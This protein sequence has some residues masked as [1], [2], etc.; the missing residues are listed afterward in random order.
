M[1]FL[2]EDVLLHT[3]TFSDSQTLCA[4]ISTCRTF[5]QH[6]AKYLIEDEVTLSKNRNVKS[7]FLFMTCDNLHRI[8]YLRRLT[9]IINR[10]T[11]DSR[12]IADSMETAEVVKELL[13]LLA[14]G[15]KLVQLA[16]IRAE[17]ILLGCRELSVA[18]C[19]L[20]TLRSLILTQVGPLTSDM[21]Q[22]LTIPLVSIAVEE[23]SAFATPIP[24]IRNPTQFLCGTQET[25]RELS[26][27]YFEVAGPN[28]SCY[29]NVHSLSLRYTD[30]LDTQHYVHAFPN[31]KNL[32][33]VYG[34]PSEIEEDEGLAALR[35]KNRHAQQLFG[36]WPSLRRYRGSLQDLYVLGISC[37]VSSIS[38]VDDEHH[39]LLPS[40]LHAVCDDA[41]PEHLDLRL[42]M[43]PTWLFHP[44]FYATFS[45]PSAQTLLHLEL[46]FY[47]HEEN[48]SEFDDL[49]QGLD[50]V[51]LRIVA[52]LRSLSRFKLTIS[53]R[54]VGL[55]S[56]EDT[57][58]LH[59]EHTPYAVEEHLVKWDLGAY[60]RRCRDANEAKTLKSVTITLFTRHAWEGV[61]VQLG[62]TYQ[63]DFGTDSESKGPSAI[64]F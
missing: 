21:L 59:K 13:L 58:I 60:A 17:S 57:K 37:H 54:E 51:V 38:I 5:H 26:A 14:Q 62:P 2:T 33:T 22:S 10:A 44:E 43:A 8:P 23:E 25:L 6:G 64:D 55:C 20:K 34:A 50:N 29:P 15:G 35:E 9:L 4:L 48:A 56:H 41:R 42:S 39:V 52:P 12:D 1:V 27:T 45:R 36:T 16:I 19:A 40:A 32:T 30:I 31:L 18:V 53:C 61:T 3:L 46:T 7:F 24:L 63:Y 28:A 11:F 49:G 47:I